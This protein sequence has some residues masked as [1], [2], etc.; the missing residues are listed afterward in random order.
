MMNEAELW[1]KVEQFFIENFDTEKNAP[2]ETYLFLI[3][4]QNWEADR[5]IQ[6]MIR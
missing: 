6:K 5:N 3:G 4:L 1:Q 2:I